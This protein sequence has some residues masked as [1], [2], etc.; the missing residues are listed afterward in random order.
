M[1]RCIDAQSVAHKVDIGVLGCAAAGIRIHLRVFYER[2]RPILLQLRG[3]LLR[4]KRRLHGRRRPSL[5][6][7]PFPET[8]CLGA[9]FYLDDAAACC[10]EALARLCADAACLDG[11]F[12]ETCPDGATCVSS[13]SFHADVRLA[14]ASASLGAISSMRTQIA[15]TRHGEGSASTSRQSFH[16]LLSQL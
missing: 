5:P 15:S 12:A 8:S 7:P 14:L 10:S 6:L 9:A 13:L 16:M 4:L 3:R 1:H 2:V 11:G